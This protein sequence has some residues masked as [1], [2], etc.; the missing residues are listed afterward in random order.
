MQPAPA[1]VG[2]TPEG[3]TPSG[4]NTPSFGEAPAASA[5]AKPAPPSFTV[6]G[7]YGHGSTT[8]FGGSGRLARPRFRTGVTFGIGYDDNLFS[9]PSSNTPT[10]VPGLSQ[11][12]DSNGNTTA[13][14]QTET[15]TEQVLVGYSFGPLGP[16]GGAHP[17]PVYKTVTTQVPVAVPDT[18]IPA[19]ERKGSFFTRAGLSLEMLRYS[20]RSLFTLDA[21][22]SASYYWDKDQDPVDYSGNVSFTYLY[23][24]TP[25]LQITTQANASYI[26]Q[27]DLSRPNTPQREI[28]GDL[29]NTL[30]R[31]DAQYRAS[32]RLSFSLTANYEGNRYTQKGEQTGD[33][34]EYTFGIEGRFLWKPRWTL[35]AEYRHGMTTY[36][37]RNDLDSTTE[38]LLVGSEFVYSP[39]L[40]G[41]LRFGEAIKSFDQGGG[42]QSAPYVES[43]VTYRS[44]ARSSILWNNR[45]GFEE[46]QGPTE[47]RLVYRGSI[48]YKYLF[49]PH[50]DGTLGV[51]MVHELSRNTVSDDEK[52]V[53]TFELQIGLDY[54]VTPHFKL[55]GSYSFMLSN[56][57]TGLEDYYRNRISL[58]GQ[59]NF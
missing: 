23:R 6:P 24:A 55:N 41:T 15:K 3:S 33:F 13:V 19:A 22:G 42:N 27:P 11:F 34:D 12:V 30:A 45:F 16:G 35:L 39:R 29:I 43:L 17:T 54:D 44:T 48:T 46:P 1:Q 25:R 57:N 56:T 50:L 49:N 47:E 5:A 10:V 53:D 59:Y 9:T 4:F 20:Q 31:I 26:S 36:L 51:N 14:Q 37:N 40:S 2:A 7:F 52:T 58:G 28:Q 32:P 21:S 8:F 18:V 38:Y